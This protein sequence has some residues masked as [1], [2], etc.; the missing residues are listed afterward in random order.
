M[1]RLNIITALHSTECQGDRMSNPYCQALSHLGPSFLLVNGLCSL[2]RQKY[3]YRVKPSLIFLKKNFRV[4]EAFVATHL[5]GFTM[6][7]IRPLHLHLCQS[8]MPE[9]PQLYFQYFILLTNYSCALHLMTK[10]LKFV[11]VIK[12]KLKLVIFENI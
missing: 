2:D 12:V 10:Q 11:M 3:I 7:T 6:T 9:I 1:A 4:N 5:L 8:S